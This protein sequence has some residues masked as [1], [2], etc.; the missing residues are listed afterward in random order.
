M[1]TTLN[2]RILSSLDGLAIYYHF[3]GIDDLCVLELYVF[4]AEKSGINGPYAR[5]CHCNSAATR[6]IVL[7]YAG[8]TAN[9][10]ALLI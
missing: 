8:S 9:S 2:G 7:E 1:R 3:C 10:A 6:T 4:S 5:P